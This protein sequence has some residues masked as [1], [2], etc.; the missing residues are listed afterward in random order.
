MAC[1]YVGKIF[2]QRNSSCIAILN[3]KRKQQGFNRN[4]S[5]ID[6]KF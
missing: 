5:S 2:D 4:S 1:A 6:D 3:T